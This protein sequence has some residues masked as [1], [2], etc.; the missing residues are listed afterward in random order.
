MDSKRLRKQKMVTEAAAVIQDFAIVMVIASVMALIFY[1]IKQ[2]MVIG[3][4][5][6]GMQKRTPTLTAAK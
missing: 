3:Y 1:K 6:A 4:I 5:A 2:P